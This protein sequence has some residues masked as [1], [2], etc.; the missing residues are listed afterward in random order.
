MLSLSQLDNLKQSGAKVVV[1]K[2]K[3][4]DKPQ[5]LEVTIALPELAQSVVELTAL[6]EKAISADKETIMVTPEIES[7]EPVPF[8]AEIRRDELGRMAKVYF[9]PGIK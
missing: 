3:P 5:E 9:S 7:K 4:G 2:Q 1:K 8:T 6:V